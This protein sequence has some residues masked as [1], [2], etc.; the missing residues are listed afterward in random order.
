MLH[1]MPVFSE[2][3]RENQPVI[4]TFF[5]MYSITAH[6]ESKSTMVKMAERSTI[7][8]FGF[9]IR[10][11]YYPACFGTIIALLLWSIYMHR[12]RADNVLLVTV[13]GLLAF[14]LVMITSIGVPKSIELSQ[15]DVLYPN[16]S[17][18]DVDC[19]FLFKRHLVRLIIGILAM[20]IA[21]KIPYKLWRKAS[22]FSYSA[23]VF[24]LIVVLIVGSSYTTF[25]TSWI[26]IF[27]TSIQPS[28]IAKLA[29]IFYLAHWMERKN[30]EVGTF[31]YG[32]LPFC[33]VGGIILLPIM[34]QPDLGSTLVI[35]SI[36][37]SMYF[38]AGAK[39]R[40]LALGALL[41]VMGAMILV[42]SVT[43]VNERMLAFLNQDENCREDYCWQTEQANIAVGTGGFW[44]K[45]LTQGVQKS[46]W[47]P[48]ASDDFIFAASAEE[49]GFIKIVAVILAYTV[50]AIRGLQVARGAPDKFS[51]L[52]A[53]GITSWVVIQ[54]YMNIAINIG[55]MPVTG[56]TLPFI[57]YGGSSL[58]T[59]LFA[60]GVLLH[61]SKHASTNSSG[62]SRRGNRRTYSPQ[63]SYYR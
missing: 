36:A 57:S 18:L 11:L 14:G 29:L 16:C 63:Y 31:Q 46:Y 53:T 51:M 25:A 21:S 40:H 56:L 9:S 4:A 35:A 58:V 19:Y 20:L 49:L 17:D 52:T 47:L 24:L 13:L 22:V 54:A 38:V 55:L 7:F 12:L 6:L 62:F 32:F 8:N 60:V 5:G 33:I 3:I 34:L 1:A 27:N 61:I 26:E 28:E 37:V 41:A 39:W 2:Y 50:F 44:G 23:A 15:S 10:V 48:Q 43:H 42:S 45:G 59:T 30:Q